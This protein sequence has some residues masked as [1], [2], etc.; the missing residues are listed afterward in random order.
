L[1]KAIGG[2]PIAFF[3]ALLA[4]LVQSKGNN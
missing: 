1:R 4:L 2:K 3:Y